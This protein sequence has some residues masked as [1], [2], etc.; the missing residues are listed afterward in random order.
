[1]RDEKQVRV[2]TTRHAG[3]GVRSTFG[4]WLSP[5]DGAGCGQVIGCT[6]VT[7]NRIAVPCQAA[8]RLQDMPNAAAGT[9]RRIALGGM[10][11]EQQ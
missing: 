8:I 1:M 6:K 10:R 4:G 9:Q 2:V 3:F 11:H 7:F 5:E